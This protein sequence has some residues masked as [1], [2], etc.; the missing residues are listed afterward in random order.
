VDGGAGPPEGF[1]PHD[2]RSPLTDPWEPIYADRRTPGRVILGLRLRPEH[3]NSRGMAH[4][5]LLAALADNAMGLSCAAE[6]VLRSAPPARLVTVSLT[7]DYLGRAEIGAWL[8]LETTFV[9]LGRSL[10]FADL[11]A[12]ADGKPVA[13]AS[14]V[15][16]AAA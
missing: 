3:T 9:K 12:T 5:G 2:R 15:F 11:L 8:A 10:S 1:V 4:G 13:K 14:A 16:S 7:V 6:A